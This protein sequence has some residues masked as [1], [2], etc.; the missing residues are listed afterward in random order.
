MKDHEL[1]WIILLANL[2][3]I[4]ILY[5]TIRKA[6]A[7]GLEDYHTNIK[8]IDDKKLVDQ[9]INEV[10]MTRENEK[11]VLDLINN[12]EKPNNNK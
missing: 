1:G 6:V 4:F 5:W 7:H 11:D 12:L 10:D 9:T 8:T 3:A 2:V